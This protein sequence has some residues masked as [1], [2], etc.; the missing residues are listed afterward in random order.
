MWINKIGQDY[1][2]MWDDSQHGHVKNFQASRDM[3]FM[4]LKSYVLAAVAAAVNESCLN[5]TEYTAFLHDIPQSKL[6]DAIEEVLNYCS[7]FQYVQKLRSEPDDKRD[8]DRERMILF[9]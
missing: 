4:I 8:L 9:L 7:D 2:K 3:F 5:I 6:A 1:C